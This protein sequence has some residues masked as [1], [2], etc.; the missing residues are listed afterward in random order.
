MLG[1]VEQ[2]PHLDV[3]VITADNVKR[4]HDHNEIECAENGKLKR[5]DRFNSAQTIGGGINADPKNNI[6][7]Q[8]Q[9]CRYPLVRCRLLQL[10]QTL[11]LRPSRLFLFVR[12]LESETAG[13]SVGDNAGGIFVRHGE[14]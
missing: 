9:K 8:N 11:S 6:Q 3:P 4:L 12:S 14:K 1:R 10:R 7:K 2:A 5:I 13:L